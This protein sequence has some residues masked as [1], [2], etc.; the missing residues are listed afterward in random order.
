MCSF[1]IPLPIA[2]QSKASIHP[3]SALNRALVRILYNESLADKMLFNF[4]IKFLILNQLQ[5]CFGWIFM[6]MIAGVVSGPL[7]STLTIERRT[8]AE[9]N[10]FTDKTTCDWPVTPKTQ[11]QTTNKQKHL[12]KRHGYG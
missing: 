10:G 9:L 2:I 11:E 5:K 12:A 7:C 1:H 6:I 3:P 8:L 4:G